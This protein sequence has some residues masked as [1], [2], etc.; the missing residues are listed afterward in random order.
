MK[1]PL[2]LLH[3]RTGLGLSQTSY[4]PLISSMNNILRRLEM[5]YVIS[6]TITRPVCM[7]ETIATIHVLQMIAL[8]RICME[9]R[10]IDSI[11]TLFQRNL[12]YMFILTHFF[13]ADGECNGGSLNTELCE[14]DWSN[15]LAINQKYPGCPVLVQDIVH[16]PRLDFSGSWKWEVR[17]R[18]FQHRGVLIWWWQLSRMQCCSARLK[19]IR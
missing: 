8:P 7:T 4:L 9:V 1:A 6:N 5:V 18:N 13:V 12:H 3:Q 16:E 17:W 11:K 2:T 19:Q 14:Y 15:C 10:Y